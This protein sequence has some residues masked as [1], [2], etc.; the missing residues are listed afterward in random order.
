MRCVLADRALNRRAHPGLTVYTRERMWWRR[1][2][3]AERNTERSLSTS[4]PPT[5]QRER[6]KGHQPEG[7]EHQAIGLG[8]YWRAQQRGLPVR[9]RPGRWRRQRE[10]RR[11]ERRR[12]WLDR[13]R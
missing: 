1:A 12:C 8:D 3:H 11:E 6:R 2:V 4:R 7:E 9:D 5:A 10:S 13:W